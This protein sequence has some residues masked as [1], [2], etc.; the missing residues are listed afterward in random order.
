[1]APNPSSFLGFQPELVSWLRTRVRSSAGVR[2]TF[3]SAHRFGLLRQVPVRLGAAPRSVWALGQ[4]ATTPTLECVQRVRPVSCQRA[5]APHSR[6]CH[7]PKCCVGVFGGSAPRLGPRTPLIVP[8]LG[9]FPSSPSLLAADH[10]FAQPGAQAS[11][12]GGSARLPCKHGCCAENVAVTL[13]VK[14]TLFR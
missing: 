13:C 4:R 10:R 12:L 1:V 2:S 5:T 8:S 7:A 6:A 3:P 14:A 11:L 9:S